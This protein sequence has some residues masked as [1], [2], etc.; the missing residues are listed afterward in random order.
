MRIFTASVGCETNTFS[1]VPT[2]LADYEIY[3]P[4]EHPDDGPRQCTAQL[5]VGRRRAARGGF[6]LIEG[7]CFHASPGGRT[8]RADYES[9]RDEILGQIAA[10]LPL[11]AIVFGLHG[12][13]AAFGYD[14]VEGDLLAHARSLV[15]EQC[16]IGVEMDPHCHL[17]RRRLALADAIVMYKEYP[18]IDTVERAEEL[19][20]IVLGALAGRIRP[21]MAAFDCEQL[22]SF[23]TTHPAMRVF[24]DAVAAMEGKNGV[25][26]ISIGHGYPYADVPEMGCRILVVG[27]GDKAAAERV[28]VE[29]GRNFQALR[30]VTTP[31]FHAIDDGI[32]AAL[33]LSGGPIAVTDAADNAG[34]GAPSDNTSI[35][36]RLIARGI[37][38]A[39]LGPLYDPI[40]VH[41]CFA[42]GLGAQVAL[43]IGGKTCAAS[44][45]PVDAVGIV[46]GL[47]RDG[48]QTYGSARVPLGDVAALCIGGVEVVMN[49][50]R[51]Q[52][53][54][55][56]LFTNVGIDPR[57]RKLLVLKSSNHFRTAYDPVIQGLVHIHSDGLLI[58]DDYRRI[59]YAK[60]GP[61]WPLD[62]HSPG[63]LVW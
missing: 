37:G 34:G 8:N 53:F 6:A 41:T 17:T 39:A 18:H 26:S 2:C 55:L 30:G 5:W 47:K 56:E 42:A 15:G 20:D 1:P 3:R 27:D 45:T 13:T 40:A 14:D 12:A 33:A 43:R 10:A 7:S 50:L 52:A 24:V 4:G 35:L 38:N 29:I 9:M 62:E 22:G 28:A 31:K 25:L 21:V 60:A 36:R 11:D 54:G 57:E 23:P 48:W 49:S 32:D 44:G 19:Y 51:T 16:F 61:F 63:R 46:A 59:A 58:R